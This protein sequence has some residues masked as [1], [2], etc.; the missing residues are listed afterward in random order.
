MKKTKSKT[1][2]KSKKLKRKPVKLVSKNSKIRPSKTEGF[3]EKIRENNPM[4]EYI[5]QLRIMNPAARMMSASEESGAPRREGGFVRLAHAREE[6]P[7]PVLNKGKAFESLKK[8]QKSALKE[9][10]QKPND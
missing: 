7:A 10:K 3:L 2:A 6:F 8:A 4:I 5:T 1:K 9:K